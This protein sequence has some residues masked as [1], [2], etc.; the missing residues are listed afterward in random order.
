MFIPLESSD[1]VNIQLMTD[2]TA[3]SFSANLTGWGAG[4]YSDRHLEVN[5][6]KYNQSAFEHEFGHLLGLDHASYVPTGYPY[7]QSL[8]SPAMPTIHSNPFYLHPTNG[9]GETEGPIMSYANHRTL[10]DYEVRL[11]VINALDLH[12][13]SSNGLTRIH[14]KGHDNTTSDEIIE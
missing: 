8:F 10:A 2:E 5:L 9:Y 6:E 14:I 13:S 7:N 3:N 11:T 4:K 12:N 1:A